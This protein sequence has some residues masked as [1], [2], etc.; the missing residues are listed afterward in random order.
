MKLVE[1]YNQAIRQYPSASKLYEV[2]TLTQ[3]L[4][5]KLDTV[6]CR[7]QRHA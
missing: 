5:T 2:L 3:K 1:L 6:A 4:D 7:T